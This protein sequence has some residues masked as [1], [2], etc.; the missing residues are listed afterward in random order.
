MILQ[1]AVWGRKGGQEK[2]GLTKQNQSYDH[3]RTCENDGEKNVILIANYAELS[4]WDQH[5]L[6]DSEYQNPHLQTGREERSKVK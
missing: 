1:G 5:G 2:E 4:L 3:M 6:K